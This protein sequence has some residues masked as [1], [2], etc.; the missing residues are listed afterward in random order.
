VAPFTDVAVKARVAGFEPKDLVGDIQQG[1]R[2]VVIG[3]AEIAAAAW[4]GPPKRG[5]RVLIDGLPFTVV[6]VDTLK[7]G[8]EIARHNLVVRGS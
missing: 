6:S 5:D 3:N 2:S 1:D 8:E 7:L 4:P